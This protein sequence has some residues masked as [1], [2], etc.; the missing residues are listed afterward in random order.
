MEGPALSGLMAH[1]RKGLR[2]SRRGSHIPAPLLV[3]NQYCVP[4]SLHT[5]HLTFRCSQRQVL[6]S[7]L[8]GELHAPHRMDML[9]IG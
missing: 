3:C 5:V 2:P 6:S 4:C 8:M 7:G 9:T 1:G